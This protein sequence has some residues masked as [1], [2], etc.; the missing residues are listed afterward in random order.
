MTDDEQRDDRRAD[1][2]L[3]DPATS[4]AQIRGRRADLETPL[5]PLGERSDPFDPPAGNAPLG[6]SPGAGMENEATDD[7]HPSRKRFREIRM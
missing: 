1:E 3:E 5:G 7:P 6:D 4:R 2:P